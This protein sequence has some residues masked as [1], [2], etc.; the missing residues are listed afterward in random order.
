MANEMKLISTVTVGAGGAT[1]IDFTSIPQI[2]TDL[3]ILVSAR[4]SVATATDSWDSSQTYGPRIN[5]GAPTPSQITIVGTGSATNPYTNARI[6][7]GA[8]PGAGST[9]NIFSN[10]TIYLPNYTSSTTKRYLAEYANENNATAV[11]LGAS[12]G[13]VTDSN[14]ITSMRL[15]GGSSMVSGSTASLYGITKGSGGATVS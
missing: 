5:G 4:S 13:Y 11:W 3:V 10:L 8:I 15:G 9:A 12:F 14:P 2:Y 7:W 6:Q 1:S